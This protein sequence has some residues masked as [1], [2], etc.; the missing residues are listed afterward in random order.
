MAPEEKKPSGAL[1]AEAS[2]EPRGSSESCQILS[3]PKR[4]GVWSALG[5]A[6][7]ATCALIAIFVFLVLTVGSGGTPIFIYS[8]LVALTF[9]MAVCVSL[10]EMASAKPHSAGQTYWSATFAPPGSATSYS[11]YTGFFATCT[12]LLWYI[13]AP[14]IA[15]Q[16]ILATAQIISPDF[17]AEP[18]HTYVTFIGVL[19]VTYIMNI[20]LFSVLQYVNKASLMV[21]NLGSLY[22][23][24]TLLVRAETK[25]PSSDVWVNIVNENGWGTGVNV[26]LSFAPALNC[27]S[28]FD[29]AAHLSEEMQQPHR[30]VP[31]VMVGSAS[32]SGIAAFIMI[33]AF[34]YCTTNAEN[35]LN[36]IGG[37]P[38]IQLMMDTLRSFPLTLI[39]SLIFVL[40]L[41]NA[42]TCLM[43][44]NSRMMWGP[45]WHGRMDCPPHGS[46]EGLDLDCCFLEMQHLFRSSLLL[47]WVL[48][49]LA[50]LWW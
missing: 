4:I 33:M 40:V 6:Y 45:R 32:L 48:Y 25:R 17:A 14:L 27:V 9:N 28:G 19:F 39:G 16:L 37:Q 26:L 7:S 30:D 12:W 29:S 20:N 5:T 49:S 13:S 43:T 2:D 46:L 31:I 1:T 3:P 50:Q 42:G 36:A 34:S 35:L 8:Y 10:A 24:I 47:G 11:Y 23:F 21:I 15:A 38:G 18:W 44:V 41:A 22:I